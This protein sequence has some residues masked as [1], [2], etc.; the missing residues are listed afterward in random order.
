MGFLIVLI[1][2]LGMITQTNGQLG[3]IIG[4]LCLISFLGRGGV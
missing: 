3:I 4:V 1:G 2:I